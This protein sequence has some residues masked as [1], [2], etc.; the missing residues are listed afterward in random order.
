MKTSEIITLY[1][2]C[3][4]G[5]ELFRGRLSRV[6]RSL[7]LSLANGGHDFPARDRTTRRPHRLQAQPRMSEP[8]H[9]ALLLLPNIMA[10]LGVT[11]DKRGF[12]RRVGARDTRRVAAT[13]IAR[14]LLRQPLQA[15]GLV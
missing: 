8:S 5:V 4:Q 11:D 15:K 12:V 14:D 2:L 9:C 1:D 13:L 7:P 10:I 3:S 6:S